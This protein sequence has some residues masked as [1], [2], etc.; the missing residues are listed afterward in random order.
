MKLKHEGYDAK[1]KERLVFGPNVFLLDKVGK[2]TSGIEE[3]VK[4]C[5]E[6]ILDEMFQKKVIKFECQTCS[7]TFD[8]KRGLGAHKR[9]AHIPCYV[10]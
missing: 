4:E 10:K 3:F 6:G 7:K 2:E 5:F 9:E 8:S 1:N